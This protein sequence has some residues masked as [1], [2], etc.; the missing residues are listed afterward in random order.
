MTNRQAQQTGA[1][2]MGRSGK[3]L[4]PIPIAFFS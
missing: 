3:P 1:M 4:H 2:L